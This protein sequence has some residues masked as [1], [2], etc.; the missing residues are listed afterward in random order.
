MPSR[1][2]EVAAADL[3]GYIAGLPRLL[4]EDLRINTTGTLTGTL[5][6]KGF[7]GSGSISINGHPTV[8]EAQYNMFEVQGSVYIA[9]CLVELTICGMTV[10]QTASSGTYLVLISGGGPITF[11]ALNV[12][13]LDKTR[14]GLSSYGSPNIIING[15]QA[16]NLDLVANCGCGIMAIE[17]GADYCTDNTRGIMV[18]RGGIAILSPDTPSTLGGSSNTNNYGAVIKN[19][20]FV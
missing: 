19:S 13:G 14:I 17:S 8:G 7:Y 9:N 3:P 11:G 10:R 18:W 2:V 5:E 4:T 6:I 15:L 16:S 12:V 1:T 20:A